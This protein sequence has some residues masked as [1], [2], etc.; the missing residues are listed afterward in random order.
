MLHRFILNV[1]FLGTALQLAAFEFP[2][3]PVAII[4]TNYGTIEVQ[5]F[6][7][8]APLA[9]ENFIRL[10]E[11]GAYVNSPF[12]RII[13]GFMI[14][15][16]D[17]TKGDGS[18]S[19]S[20]WGIPFA[21]EISN[22]LRFDVP[23]RVAMANAGPNTNGS[24]FFIT[25]KKCRWLDDRHTIFGTVIAGFDTVSAIEKLGT[26]WGAPRAITPPV[27]LKVYLKESE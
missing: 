27:M 18:K 5:L 15:G 24:Q 25:T 10:A 12:H 7:K 4:E 2:E 16:G 22:T 19:V 1:L 8:A 23:W 9:C 13:L 14:Q 21:D 3:S 26:Q 20:L 6:P 17:T 11:E